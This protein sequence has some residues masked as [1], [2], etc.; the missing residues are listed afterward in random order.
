MTPEMAVALDELKERGPAPWI[1]GWLKNRTKEN[2]HKL[3]TGGLNVKP[4][5]YLFATPSSDSVAVLRVGWLR[6]VPG[7]ADEYEL[8][9]SVTPLRGEYQTLLQQAEDT[10]PPNWK[11]SKPLSRPSPYHRAQIRSPVSLDPEGYKK[12]CPRPKDW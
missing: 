5:L 6:K 12:V 3:S 4:G 2:K 7:E 10:P 8:L 9:N 11:W 1:W